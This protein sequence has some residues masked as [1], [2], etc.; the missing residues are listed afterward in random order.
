MS[1]RTHKQKYNETRLR[2]LCI[3]TYVKG[4]FYY[5]L[6]HFDHLIVYSNS[7]E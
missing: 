3:N 7:N 1:L 2:G 6:S 4:T 5:D